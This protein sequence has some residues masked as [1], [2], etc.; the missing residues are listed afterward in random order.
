[1]TFGPT[2]REGA[3]RTQFVMLKDAGICFEGT[4]EELRASKDP[5]LRTFLS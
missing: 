2:D 4:A 3:Q 1:V 5:Y